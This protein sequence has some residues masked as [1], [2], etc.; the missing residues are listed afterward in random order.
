MIKI[1]YDK[2][3]DMK[4][5]KGKK[6]AI[7]G[8]GSQGHAHANNLRDS[9]VDVIVAE[10]K[11]SANWDKAKKAGFT[12]MDAGAAAKVADVMMILLPDEYQAEIYKAEIAPN[13]KKGVFL[14]FAHGFNIHYGQIVPP[15]D[16]NVFMAAPKGPGHLVRSEYTKGSGVPMLIANYQDPSKKTRALALAYAS[17][18]GGGRAGVIETT[19]K[20]ET[21]TD[22]FGE[23]VVLC[24]G[25][26]AL[27]KAGFE[28][29]VEAGYSPEMAY[30]ECQHEVK[31]I[32]DL[33][34][35]GG[36]ANMRYSVSNTAEYGDYTV[37]PKI[38]DAHVRESM[39][40]A[41]KRIQSGEFAN[42]WMKEN[43]DG[44]PN[45]KRMREAFA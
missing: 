39:K 26:V 17:A 44:C 14:G 43:E 16:V 13:M 33:I 20:E 19:F 24:G 1:Y 40:K 38:I 21:E 35:E 32:T 45:F 27:I 5:L 36:I 41:L 10:L 9:K 2:D 34:Y 29:L 3:A 28:T 6:V 30:F 4:V 8:Y 25:L 31:L 7:I 11:G 15:A 12:V 42:D 22:L 37:G 18:I 23:Q